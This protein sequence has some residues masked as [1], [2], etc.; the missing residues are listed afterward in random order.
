MRNEPA[1]LFAGAI[2]L[3]LWITPHAMIYDSTIS[4]IPAILFWEMRP[5]CRG[6]WK[7][8]FALVWVATFLSGPLTLAQLKILPLALQVS[9]PILMFVLY[10]AYRNL[11]SSS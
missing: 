3:T 6:F 9:I 4:L 11:V 2:C 7:V 8:L 1:L 5:T 10:N